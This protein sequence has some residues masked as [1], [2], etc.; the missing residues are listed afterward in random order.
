L[1]A[2]TEAEGKKKMT[3]IKTE[4]KEVIRVH[5]NPSYDGLTGLYIDG[6]LVAGGD[7][8][9]DK[10]HLAIKGFID[11]LRYMGWGGKVLDRYWA[12]EAAYE[13]YSYG[14]CLPDIISEFP[15]E[16]TESYDANY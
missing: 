14:N 1:S 12:G 7:E 9:H 8:Y 10:A 3:E 15:V 6:K 5:V 11:G 4:I 16:L 13:F 2:L